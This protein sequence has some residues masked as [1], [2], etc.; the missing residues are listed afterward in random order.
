MI[1]EISEYV[2]N[3]T[4]SYVQNNKPIVGANAFKHEAGIH[5]AG[6]INNKKTY[7]IINP[8]DYGIYVDSIVIGIHSGKNA[9]VDK[10]KKLDFNVDDYDIDNI[11]FDIK[12]YCT[13][14]SNI[15]DNDFI[16]IINNNEKKK[17]VYSK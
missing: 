11:V 12:N 7:E 17:L 14:N 16:K 1:Y 6:V 4:N 2:Q 10:M 8:E 3:I 15:T 13:N 5:Q 9:I